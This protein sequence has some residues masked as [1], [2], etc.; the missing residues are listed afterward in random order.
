[1]TKP[2]KLLRY[3]LIAVPA[4]LSMY[5]MDYSD[6]DRFTLD[7]LILLLLATLG[8]RLPQR[9]VPAAAAAEMLYSVWLCRQ[10]GSLMVFPSLSVLLAYFRLRSRPLPL[11]LA[12]I[13]LAALNAALP[14]PAPETLIWV[15]VSFVLT[16]ALCAQLDSASRGREDMRMLYDELRRKHFELDEA[17][18]RLLQFTAQVE[19]A[20]QSEERVRIGRQLH[21]DIGHK[22]I[23]IKMMM[24]AALHTLPSSPDTGM[25]ML[26]QVR[27][28]LA[29]SMDDLRTAVRRV[30]RET[31]LEGAYALDRL[32]EETG[33]DTGIE[34][35]Y[36]VEGAPFPLYPSLRVVLYKNAREAITNALRH[37]KA[38]SIDI[39]L[40]YGT[41][42]VFMEVSNNGKTDK[43]CI[44]NKHEAAD[45]APP[46]EGI[47]GTEHGR[48]SPAATAAIPRL[49]SGM[50]MKGMQERTRLVGGSLELRTGY[51]FTVVTRLPV[52]KQSE[53]M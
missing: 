15:N 25:K 27:D 38:T 23:R 20:A 6:Y 53:I 52:H 12:G 16:A 2:L 44:H 9:F 11:V 49:T 30:G 40:V 5:I 50:G 26:N 43:D 18:A 10:Y 39:R 36:R 45:S 47:S 4:F 46:G 19:N 34:T 37:G 28:Q 7:V 33:R 22:L 17:R 41:E 13:H 3:G 31:R 1:M 35:S 48:M 8:A 51:P 42:E 24:E 14:S 32:L 21:D 29:E